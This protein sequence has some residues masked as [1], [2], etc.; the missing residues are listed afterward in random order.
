MP[1]EDVA[2]AVGPA[3]RRLLTQVRSEV[4]HL[5]PHAGPAGSRCLLVAAFHA[6][7]VAAERTGLQ[8]PPELLPAC[9]V[10]TAFD[11]LL[12]AP[13]SLADYNSVNT[14]RGNQEPRSCLFFYTM[15]MICT[16]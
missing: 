16:L 6:T 12:F 1:E 8:E 3:D 11:H 15:C 14:P 5:G 4:G 7:A 13:H 10:L 9:S 2:A